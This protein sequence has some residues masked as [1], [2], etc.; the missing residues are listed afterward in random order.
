MVYRPRI[1]SELSGDQ[2]KDGANIK[3]SIGPTDRGEVSTDDVSV[4]VTNGE[5]LGDGRKVSIET[6]VVKQASGSAC[7]SF[8]NTKVLCSVNGP[9]AI[10]HRNDFSNK[11]TLNCFVKLAPFSQYDNMGLSQHEADSKRIKKERRLSKAVKQS[12]EGS[13]MLERFPKSVLE[14]NILLLSDDGGA[15]AVAVT[16]TSL[17]LADSGVELYDLVPCCSVG[18]IKDKKSRKTKDKSNFIFDPKTEQIDTCTSTICVALMPASET[19]T[20]LSIEGPMGFEDAGDATKLCF[21]GC[22]RLHAEMKNHLVKKA[23]EQFST[24][25][26][27]S[28]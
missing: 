14:V 22:T 8:G 1:V 5:S 20:E 25:P 6:G 18:L 26:S 3:Y 13:I 24:D 7:V 10:M 27:G 12:I 17:A 19:L 23:T 11:G 9:K 2:S 16:C 15:Q 28:N 4:E 21:V